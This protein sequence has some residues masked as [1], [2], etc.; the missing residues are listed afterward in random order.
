MQVKILNPYALS[1]QKN[2]IGN[3]VFAIWKP[4]VPPPPSGASGAATAPSPPPP[5]PP[6]VWTPNS[7]T[8]SPLTPKKSFRPVHF[9]ESPP[10]RKKFEEVKD[11]SKWY[12]KMYDTIHKN[13]YDNDYVTI[14]YKSRRDE[15]PQR[16]SSSRSQY[17]Y[18]DPRSGYLSEPEGGLR[19]LTTSTWSD[20][21]DSDAATGPRRRTASVQEDRRDVYST[22]AS[23]RASHEVYK[24]Q[25]GKIENYTPGKSSVVEKEAKQQNISS[26]TSLPQASP[27]EK[28]D[29]TS[30]I[31][32]KS[33]MASQFNCYFTFRAL[34]ESGYESDS[35][36]IFK[37]REET[38]APLSP[39]DR[40]AAYR[41]LQAGG[42]PP[43]RGFRSPAPP[44]TEE[45]DIE[46]IPLTSTLT[47]I[48]V[49]RKSP[50]VHEVICYPITSIEKN[51]T[52]LM[53][54][55]NDDFQTNNL[56]PPAPPKR[57]S[58]KCSRTLHLINSGRDKSIIPSLITKEQ[59]NIEL[60]KEKI[61]NKLNR[62]KTHIIM[63]S[64]GTDSNTANRRKN[65][66]LSAPP[67][68]NRNKIS[69]SSCIK[70]K[71][72]SSEK[73]RD[74]T[75]SFQSPRRTMLPTEYPTGN[76]NRLGPVTSV[77]IEGGVGRR[78]PISNILDKAT[79]L[80]KLWS[81]QK[82]NEKIDVTKLKNK[83]VQD[84]K[85]SVKTVAGNSKQTGV[86][87]R[88]RDMM[89]TSEKLQKAKINN[90]H[91]HSTPCLASKR[92][93]KQ[94]G[95]NISSSN[96]KNIQSVSR[97]TS[98]IYSNSK[99]TQGIKTAVI[100]N[101][102]K[103]KQSEIVNV[104][105]KS[106]VCHD[107]CNKKPKKPQK[108]I[109]KNLDKSLNEKKV[110][111]Q[112]PK[113]LICTNE[114]G[115][116]LPESNISSKDLNKK[117]ISIGEIQNTRDMIITD[118]F[119]QH[120]LCRET[121]MSS[122]KHNIDA[123]VISSVKDKAQFFQSDLHNYVSPMS[124]SYNTY[125]TY[126]KPVSLSRFK[127]WDKNPSPARVYK[128]RSIS[129]PGKMDG[130]IRKF[131]SL[132][133][134]SDEFGSNTSVCT[135]RSKS[136]PT[137]NKLFFSQTTRPKSPT[138]IFHKKGSD[139]EHLNEKKQVS[140]LAINTPNQKFIA[141]NKKIKL[142]ESPLTH[143]RQHHQQNTF[144][145]V[146]H[147]DSPTLSNHSSFMS[148][149]EESEDEQLSQPSKIYF[150]QTSRPVSPK[151]MKNIKSVNRSKSSS[152]V[153]FR[154]PSYRKI[155]HSKSQ[156]KLLSRPHSIDRGKRDEMIISESMKSK[157]KSDSD[158]HYNDPEYGE[159][160]Q[161]ILNCKQR[162]ER[163]RE[164]NT[165]Y[166]YLE[167]VAELEK[168]TSLF[169]LS[170][171][172]RNEEIIDF[173]R[174]KKIRAI[175]RAEEELNNL[176][177]KLRKA[178]IEK[179]F[180]FYP[181][182]LKEFRWNHNKE[183]GLKVKEKSVEDLK[184]TFLNISTKDYGESN[185]TTSKD[186]Y[187]PFW[188]G[189]SVAETAFNI[190]TRNAERNCQKNSN[191]PAIEFNHKTTLNDLRKKIGLGKHLWSSLSLEQVS[192]LKNQL[193]A[194]YSKE[195]ESKLNKDSDKFSIEV[196]KRN[197]GYNSNLHVRC[198][199]LI[200]NTDN[201]IKNLNEHNKSKSIAA[202]CPVPTEKDFKNNV[203]KIHMTLTENEKKKLSQT[204]SKEVISRINGHES[205][206]KAPVQSNLYITSE[207]NTAEK[208]KERDLTKLKQNRHL[209]Y[210]SDKDIPSQLSA[211]D[212]ETG[213]SDTSNITVIHNVPKKEVQDKVKYFESV[214]NRP[215]QDKTTP[216]FHNDSK[217]SMIINESETGK[218]SE[219]SG[220]NLI[221]Q[222]NS[223]TNIKEY[224]GESEKNKFIPLPIK[225][226]LYL[227][228]PSPHRLH[229][230]D[231]RTPDTL[232]YSSE[233]TI[234]RSRSPSPTPERYW[235]AYLKLA[236]PGEVRR[237]ARRFDS[238]SA[239]GAVLRRY[240]SD[241]ELVRS[242]CKDNF[243]WNEKYSAQKLHK[244][245]FPV[246]RG[247]SKSKNRYM[248]HIDIISKLAQLHK[249]STQH[250]SR[251]AEEVPEFRNGEVERIRKRFEVMSLLGQIYASA[252][253]ISSLKDFAPHL[254][255]SWIAHRYPKASDNNRSIEDP[256]T[257]VHGRKSPVKKELKKPLSNERLKLTSI[258][259]TD[260]VENPPF[261]PSVHR[262]ISRY[263]PPHA[264][265]RP[266]ST[267]WTYRLAPFVTSARN[268][269]TFQESDSAPDPPQRKQHGCFSDSDL[270]TVKS[271][272]PVR[273]HILNAE[274]GVS[275]HEQVRI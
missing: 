103:K 214:T 170:H 101:L 131:D 234:W 228:S 205:R 98:N 221:V 186:T 274:A 4:G 253:D 235:R 77:I 105:E 55:K 243:F 275:R 33:N 36:L 251:S 115:D 9:E 61:S 203:N 17:A 162:S 161:D 109:K 273:Q 35:T 8:S 91:T 223:C 226:D 270:V 128:P 127:M 68:L 58:S 123:S 201:E 108:T 160:V 1:T 22:L 197:N 49:H 237:L 43:L 111:H 192:T 200:S 229:A 208:N 260:S 189:T 147:F 62:E 13:K 242:D 84:R 130:S 167:R 11:P 246:V 140:H 16:V 218:I 171:R 53:G 152:P 78:T 177:K 241:P 70:L 212:T 117:R 121:D 76:R 227:R 252:P 41:D 164:L 219:G 86:T 217:E 3:I 207:V 210:T 88:S 230:S 5:P 238:P 269:V 126:R 178:Q 82:R 153:T 102:K 74:G 222:S 132:E 29:L 224:F 26:T 50:N 213:G 173:D 206:E 90:V 52:D 32:S 104:K 67:V 137:V 233:E 15:E 129:W 122:L 113:E 73:R 93:D 59:S 2:H 38:E 141:P 174:W 100:N 194:I 184:D 190:N 110:Q 120:L 66:S 247:P 225:P 193:N 209:V 272:Q 47:K 51:V 97:S 14:R 211:S 271:Y 60:I 256:K 180:L 81:A 20:A 92:N 182:D 87:H 69:V 169:N 25:P 6:P 191:K 106:T 119:F 71:N 18:F 125:L 142:N 136:E 65:T 255:G 262:P 85:L 42:E 163:F 89:R 156:N 143:L 133:K 267:T 175:E 188:R 138:V 258:L 12:K 34:K 99:S 23:T 172:K 10:A 215:N 40:R 56:E 236:Q 158:I 31:L 75:S 80:D 7:T 21:Y 148:E 94:T 114:F 151:I 245:L 79:S 116:Y 263:V 45:S 27:K 198:N 24:T 54:P 266:P 57:I 261:D 176:Y 185:Q 159:Y 146:G 244:T 72:A 179:D 199:S 19:R 155:H 202:I 83:L 204:L 240:R 231:R 37:R 96:I 107:Q 268:T 95:S 259:K 166:S 48:R 165:Y 157:T 44:R 112:T 249:S 139:G 63:K 46:Y 183:V 195:L 265:P 28:K 154:S 248:P 187:K 145:E 135:N 64:S 196:P 181:R 168:A 149:F 254:E 118:S 39:A 220:K 144:G 232:P 264:P 124:N 250:R 150:S 30:A 216:N 134:S 257:F 239:A